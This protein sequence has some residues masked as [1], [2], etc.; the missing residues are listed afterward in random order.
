MECPFRHKIRY[1]IRT[2]IDQRGEQTINRSAKTSGGITHFASESSTVHK[3]CLTRAD[4]ANTI[5]ALNEMTGLDDSTSTYKPLR[6]TQ[7]TKS[8]KMIQSVMQVLE[9]EFVNPFSAKVDSDKLVHLSSGVSVDDKAADEILSTME[10]GQ[11]LRNDFRKTRLISKEVD[12]HATIPQKNYKTFS[13]A[14][15]KSVQLSKDGKI[16]T[17]EV[18]RNMLSSLISYEMKTGKLIDY[19][20]VLRYPL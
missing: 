18:N 4:S 15:K 20:K 11:G 3:W 19:E 7:I 5:D 17:A 1:P 13:K 6:P 12:F 14:T 8:E 16:K 2:A 9:H 10:I